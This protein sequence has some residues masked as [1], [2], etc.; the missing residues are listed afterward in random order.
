MSQETLQSSVTELTSSRVMQ[1]VKNSDGSMSGCLVIPQEDFKKNMAIDLSPFVKKLQSADYVPWGVTL[2][3][4]REYNPN[5]AVG[6]EEN[7]E[8]HPYFIDGE[9]GA[10]LLAFVYDKISGQRTP[11]IFF[12]V[13]N[14]KRQASADVMMDTLGNQY[15][16]AVAKVVANEV[17]IGWSLYSRIDESM[18]ELE[19]TETPK[20][21]FK[22]SAL[23]VPA[24]TKPVVDEYD[25]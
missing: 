8:G 3:F 1:T 2:T 9:R 15:Q 6:F 19:E 4:L 16:R 25:F 13:R 5:L 12:P 18:L 24:K 23:K 22:P 17:G 14:N 10:Y 11:S 21:N 20:T 7:A